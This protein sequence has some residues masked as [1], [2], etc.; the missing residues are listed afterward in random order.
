[1]IFRLMDEQ[2]EEDE[3]KNWCDQEV[4]KTTGSLDRKTEK[5]EAAKT[6]LDE[7]VARAAML[8]KEIEKANAAVSDL[9]KSVRDATDLRTK[10]KAENAAALKDAEDA[11]NAIAEAVSV[12]NQFYKESGGA[13]ALLQEP[14]KLPEKP[15]MWDA[16]Y[17]GFADPK[18]QP[19]G[20]VN[21]L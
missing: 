3:H 1:M 17:T 16:P 2:K 14:V 20:I 4:E 15:A 19:G 5:S 8:A 7:L 10:N 13:A 9:K 11:Q 12:L 6:D 21:V 18:A